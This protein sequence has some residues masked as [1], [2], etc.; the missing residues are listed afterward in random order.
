MVNL[1]STRKPALKKEQA[2]HEQ[3]DA[4]SDASQID[5]VELPAP[6]R[7]KRKASESDET[8]REQVEAFNAKKPK[9]KKGYLQ[10]VAEM[11][12]DVVYEVRF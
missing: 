7:R 9:V 1:R 6:K 8:I 11:P 10:Q 3:Q 4:R 5:F 12:I 2:N